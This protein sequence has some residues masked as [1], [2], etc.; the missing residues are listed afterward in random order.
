MGGA[1]SE[2]ADH[3]VARRM[4]ATTFTV[5]KAGAFMADRAV[6][7]D[8]LEPEAREYGGRSRDEPNRRKYLSGA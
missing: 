6:G 8:W 4:D 7:S 5:R 1:V 3:A 2:C